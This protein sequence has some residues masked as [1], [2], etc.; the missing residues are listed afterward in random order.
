[1]S[2]LTILQDVCDSIGLDSPASVIGNPDQDIKQLLQILLLEGKLLA[3]GYDW[4]ELQQVATITTLAQEDQGAVATLAAGFKKFINNT[5]WNQDIRYMVQG[6]LDPQTWE[7]VKAQNYSGPY[8]NF[9][10]RGGRFLMYPIPA[11]GQ[12][13]K[14]EFISKNWIL[15]NDGVTTLARFANDNDTCLL[16]ED[17]LILGVRWRWLSAKNFDYAEAFRDYETMKSN[18]QA[19]N[20]GKMVQD[21]GGGRA[22][23]GAFVPRFPEGNWAGA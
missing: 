8:P 20:G 4:Q 19:R 2:L 3:D 6:S 12:I 1:M 7:G 5:A 22:V 16:D 17:L 13:I 23:V 15:S 18:L 21:M 14:F 9:R 11:A 10:I